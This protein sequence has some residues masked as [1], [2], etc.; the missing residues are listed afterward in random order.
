MIIPKFL[1]PIIDFFKNCYAA[2]P[3]AVW[4]LIF[5][6]VGVTAA[7]VAGYV[8]KSTGSYTAMLFIA[9]GIFTVAVVSGGMRLKIGLVCLA[10]LSIYGGFIYLLLFFILA[11]RN[12]ISERKRRRAEIRRKLQYTLPNYNNTYLRER[13][14]TALHTSCE[15]MQNNMEKPLRL[16][17]VMEL[18]SKLKASPLTIAERLRVDEMGKYVA[19]CQQK[20]EWTLE[21]TQAINDTL[22]QLLKISAKYDLPIY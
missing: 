14:Q 1:M 19:L 11:I 17:Y 4:L 10:L 20:E 15:G 2:F 22:A 6:V 12:R 7:G 8:L 18:L 5:L 3:A 21:E 9:L 13:L 16:H